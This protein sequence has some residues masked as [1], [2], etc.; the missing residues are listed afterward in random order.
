[1]TTIEFCE[2]SMKKVGYSTSPYHRGVFGDLQE[3][4]GDRRGRRQGKREGY[5]GWG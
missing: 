2:K 4:R 3:V 1:M 5:E